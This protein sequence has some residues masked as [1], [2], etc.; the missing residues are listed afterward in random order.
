MVQ[1]TLLNAKRNNQSNLKLSVLSSAGEKVLCS[2][3]RFVFFHNLIFILFFLKNRT[4]PQHTSHRGSSRKVQRLN[5]K[6]LKLLKRIREQKSKEAV[7]KLPRERAFLPHSGHCCRLIG[8]KSAYLCERAGGYLP[9]LTAFAYKMESA[10]VEVVPNEATFYSLVWR[11]T[12]NACVNL[13]DCT[14][15]FELSVHEVIFYAC[16]CKSS[17]VSKDGRLRAYPGGPGG[18]LS[19]RLMRSPLI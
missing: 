4:A 1:K 6:S 11:S 13:L 14:M 17:A 5:L 8:C 7:T 3:W 19:P 10:Q 15:Q 18:W 2:C 12:K 9:L 16:P